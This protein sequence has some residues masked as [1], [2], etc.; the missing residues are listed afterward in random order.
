VDRVGGEFAAPQPSASHGPRPW[1]LSHGGGF[2][3][4]LRLRDRRARANRAVLLR[5]AAGGLRTLSR[6]RTSGALGNP[7]PGP[8]SS[9]APAN[10]R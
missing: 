4:V 9:S 7:E 6:D 5:G 1:L 2:F 8:L 3:V 10:D